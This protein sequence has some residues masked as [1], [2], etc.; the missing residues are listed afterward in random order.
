MI[1]GQSGRMSATFRADS[2][3][4]LSSVKMRFGRGDV[5]FGPLGRLIREDG[6]RVLL[7]TPSAT[8]ESESLTNSAAVHLVDLERDSVGFAMNTAPAAGPI[9]VRVDVPY[10]TY[11]G[12]TRDESA[13]DAA[14]DGA[15]N[16]YVTG[17]TASAN[18]PLEGP[19]QDEL[20]GQSDA[21]VTKIAQSGKRWVYSTYLGGNDYDHGTG[22]G[23]G[24]YLSVHEGPV[25][26]S[27]M[28]AAVLKPGMIISNEP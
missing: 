10:V 23:V 16:V 25:S 19:Y 14:F 9:E 12:G 21:Y 6:G 4:E 3:D 1:E 27:R 7:G 2:A 8:V 28:G 13:S 26:I 24:S 5:G 15:G 20:G 17:S 11:L 18:F 22:H